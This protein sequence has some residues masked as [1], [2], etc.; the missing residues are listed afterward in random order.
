[1][2]RVFH[3]CA[4]GGELTHASR[5]HNRHLGPVLLI[6]EGFTDFV[7]RADIVRVIS[8]NEKWVTPSRRLEHRSANAS[9][10]PGVKKSERSQ[11]ITAL[12]SQLL[13]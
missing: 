13:L 3:N 1:M 11:S 7:L 10:S 12:S 8:K 6:L 4:V 5:I 9:C 2:L